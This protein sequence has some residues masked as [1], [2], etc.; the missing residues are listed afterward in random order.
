MESIPTILAV[1]AE[2]G[3][4]I[5]YEIEVNDF[6]NPANYQIGNAGDQE[7]YAYYLTEEITYRFETSYMDMMDPNLTLYSD[8]NLTEQLAYNDDTLGPG[9]SLEAR[10]DYTPTETKYY[11]IVVKGQDSGGG[12]TGTGALTVAILD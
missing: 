9:M 2:D 3:T 12:A 8:D 4:I 10:I 7:V 6:E 5:I 11:Y 1:K